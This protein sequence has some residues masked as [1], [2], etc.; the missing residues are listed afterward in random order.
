VSADRRRIALRSA[1]IAAAVLVFTQFVLPGTGGGR[2]TPA[3]ILF[4]GAVHGLLTALTAAGIIVIYR[5]TRVVNFAQTAIGA[6]GAEL[7][8]QL[9]QLTKVPF[10]LAFPA[11]VVLAGLCGLVFDLSVGRRFF[12]S[13]RLVL[14]VATIAAAGLLGGVSRR[15]VNLLPFFPRNRTLDQLLG[16]VSLREHLPFPG[17]TFHVG[18]F[19]TRFG[20]AEL[21]AIQAAVVS[22][23]LVGLFFRWTRAGVAVRA[24]AE[25]PDRASLLGISVGTLTSTAWVIAALLSGVSVIL[26]GALTNPGT[27]GGIAPTVLLPALAAAV[28]ARMRSL[29]IAVGA[30]VLLGA[31]TES[32]TWSYKHDAPLVDLALFLVVAVGLLAQRRTTVRAE[33]DTTSG[34]QATEEQRP[35]P[36]EMLA[37]PSVRW[38]RYVLAA[39]ALVGVALYPFLVSTG[40]TVLGGVIALNAVVALSIVVLTGW[41]GQVSLGQFGLVAIGAVVGGAITGTS[42]A[43]FWIAVPIATVLTAAFAV[44]IGI[45]AL[46]IRGL[47]LAVTTFAFAIAVSSVLF[48]KRYF[49]WLLPREVRRPALLLVNFEDERSMYFL[50]VGVLV[51]AIVLVVNLRRSFFGRALIGGRDNEAN[52]ESFGV[53]AVRAKLTAFAVS[54]ALAGLAGAVFAAQQRGVSGASFVPQRSIDLFLLAVLG[55]VTSV[56]GALLGALYFNLSTYFFPGNVIFDALQPFAVLLLLYIAPGGLIALVNQVRDAWLRV[57]AQR[58]GMVVPGLFSEGDPRQ[59]A[60]T[61]LTL[62]EPS[63]DD[64]LALLP[65]ASRYDL[66][67]RLPVGAPAAADR[68]RNADAEALAAA[69]TSVEEVV[70]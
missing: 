31:A 61:V 70:G 66:D 63:G 59:T 65:D 53:V 8:F 16:S 13:P 50:C 32:A 56:P 24:M 68:S 12:K 9:L 39:L 15:A 20:F 26:T 30:A 25:N 14:T 57:I 3:A 62:A 23:V 36:R 49:G 33:A 22:L 44:V 21:F 43:T 38:T 27:A 18:S 64:G 4:A 37:V 11:G 69:A 51:L 40:P 41:A 28:L 19:N 29:P 54:G 46:R 35:I 52:L 2:G 6:A 60:G 45:P 7:T 1:A 34:W 42:S 55:G 10:V 48:E 67:T 58:R 47:F 17:Y 5:T